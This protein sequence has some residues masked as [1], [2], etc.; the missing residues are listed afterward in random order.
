MIV[1]NP[2]VMDPQNGPS[3]RKKRSQQL[4]VTR[5]VGGSG[6]PASDCALV[7]RTSHGIVV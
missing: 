3:P 4:G 1:P 5:K 7:G 6:P 2:V